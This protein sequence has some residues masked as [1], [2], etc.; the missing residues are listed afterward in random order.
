MNE[1]WSLEEEIHAVTLKREIRRTFTPLKVYVSIFPL[2]QAFPNCG[3]RTTDDTQQDS[4]WY[5]TVLIKL[6]LKI[7]LK[8]NSA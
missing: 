8:D 4:R 7:Y 2:A 3:T 5:A 6:V 1:N